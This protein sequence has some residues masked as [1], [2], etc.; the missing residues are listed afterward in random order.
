MESSSNIRTRAST[1]KELCHLNGQH[2]ATIVIRS[3]L[4]L[5]FSTKERRLPCATK[6]FGNPCTDNLQLI[7]QSHY[8]LHMHRIHQ[9]RFCFSRIRDFTCLLNNPLPVL[10]TDPHGIM[11]CRT[12]KLRH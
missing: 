1:P 2:Y 7:E 8:A 3:L 5:V 10:A 11:L 9:V 12:S 6:L 4:H